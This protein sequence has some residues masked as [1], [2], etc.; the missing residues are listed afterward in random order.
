MTETP[1]AFLP[2]T[3]AV[4][5]VTDSRTDK[6]DKS[7]ALLVQR[8]TE[9]NHKLHEKALAPDDIYQ[10]RAVVSRWIA[11]PDVQ[12]VIST[13]GTGVTGR[14]GT[15]EALLPLLDKVIDGFGEVF[16]MVSPRHYRHFRHPVQGPG[17]GGQ[18]HLC[19]LSA[20]FLRGLPGCLGPADLPPAGPPHP[21]L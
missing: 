6:T 7:G 18:R 15:P 20:G 21:A 16:R 9:A 5:T 1:R 12:V 13:G 14:D 11:D 4:L 19:F 17:G 10:I 3:I 2:V 8:I